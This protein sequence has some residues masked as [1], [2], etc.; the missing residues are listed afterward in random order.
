MPPFYNW[1]DLFTFTQSKN[2]QY[3]IHYF[4]YLE[5]HRS[6]VEKV[7]GRKNLYTIL[8][9]FSL[10]SHKYPYIYLDTLL[11]DTLLFTNLYQSEEGILKILKFWAQTSSLPNYRDNMPR[12][13]IEKISNRIE[14][15]VSAIIRSREYSYADLPKFIMNYYIFR[16]L[17]DDISDFDQDKASNTLTIAT[18]VGIKKTRRISEDIYMQTMELTI[19]LYYK[20]ILKIHHNYFFKLKFIR[21]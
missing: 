5:N 12:N 3:P 2:I 4:V 17:A 18:D 1:L 9:I 11:I 20:Q 21:I 6:F 15:G 19:P 13:T 14:D 16:Q 10:F 7:I 8:E